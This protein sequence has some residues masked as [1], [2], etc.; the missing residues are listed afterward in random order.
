MLRAVS[1]GRRLDLA[2]A[3]VA[4]G[5][6][7]QERRWVQEAVYGTV[8][9]RGRLDFLLDLHLRS[10]L[11]S[12]SP[13][14]LDLMR[15]GSYQLLY[16][17]AV[18]PYAAISQTVDQ[19]KQ[20]AGSGVARLANGVLR[21]LEREGGDA[22]RFPDFN[23][24]PAAHLSTWG[25]HPDWLIARW[26][27]R[28]SPDEVRRIVEHDNS[29]APISFRPLGI[30]VPEAAAR[31]KEREA[32]FREVGSGI[33]CFY[34]DPGTDPARILEAVPGIVQ[35]PA[36]ALVTSYADIPPGG[37]VGDLCAAPG[38]KSLA[39]AQAGAY[40]LAA[41]RSWS[42]LQLLKE[43]LRRVGGR[44]DLVVAR[45]E[46][47]PFLELQNLL[48]DVPCTGTGTLRRNPDARWRLTPDTLDELVGLQRQ[49]L[50]AGG[51][52]VPPGGILI[53]STCSLEGEENQAQ[54]EDFL[55][56]H[57]EFSVVETGMVS[58]ELVGPEGYLEVTPLQRGFDGAFAAR[59]VHRP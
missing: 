4:A 42:R 37:V 13:L 17:D 56:E 53:Y 39:V 27:R 14:L 11:S 1:R 59:M 9:L 3:E 29:P 24:E 23:Q 54:V 8:R 47:P 15:L 44:V 30:A 45:A 6:A 12:L 40:V 43:N 33:P 52:L 2:L 22:A 28:W 20:V 57:P 38:G 46:K 50:K 41:D 58:D 48:L 34:L 16:M 18:P 5:L 21:S 36:A 31:L 55:T 26:L 35:D 19:V 10:G 25:S 49:I 51:R 7:D 32:G